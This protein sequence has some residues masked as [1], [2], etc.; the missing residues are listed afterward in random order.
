MHASVHTAGVHTGACMCVV[1]W[2][3]CQQLIHMHTPQNNL[4]YPPRTAWPSERRA[5]LKA[6][7]L[8]SSIFRYCTFQL[9]IAEEEDGKSKPASKGRNTQNH[10]KIRTAAGEEGTQ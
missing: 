4:N 3:T 1:C 9:G 6:L 10:V 7:A 5:K 8:F 2:C